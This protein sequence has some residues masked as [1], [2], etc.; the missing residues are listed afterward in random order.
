MQSSSSVR[1]NPRDRKASD[2]LARR[3]CLVCG[4]RGADGPVVLGRRLCAKCER[5]IVNLDA[6]ARDYDFYVAKIRQA[7]RSYLQARE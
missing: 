7:W 5:A 3:A 1:E 2:A 6:A 4:R